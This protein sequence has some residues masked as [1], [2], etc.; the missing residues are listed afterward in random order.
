MFKE[1][2][3]EIIA[4]ISNLGY[5]LFFTFFLI[6]GSKEFFEQT[7]NASSSIFFLLEFILYIILIPA[8][9]SWSI[10]AYQKQKRKKFEDDLSLSISV[11]S[12]AKVMINSAM[13]TLLM[14]ISTIVKMVFERIS[15]KDFLFCIILVLAII[16][17]LTSFFV[18]I[19]LLH[20][21]ILDKKRKSDLSDKIEDARKQGFTSIIEKEK[22]SSLGFKDSEKWYEFLSSSYETKEE[23]ESVKESEEE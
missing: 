15:K 21:K 11:Q 7:W 18:T 1:R 6:Y 23:W 5:V 3:L 4:L 13:I 10:L 17:A 14:T 9:I 2:E 22:A 19:N 20:L 16:V 12:F 8:I